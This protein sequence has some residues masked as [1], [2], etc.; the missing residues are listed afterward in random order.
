MSA[1]RV[2]SDIEMVKYNGITELTFGLPSM[3]LTIE[4][5]NSASLG[6]M[7]PLVGVA[8]GVILKFEL[9]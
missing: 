8:C 4:Y 1:R 2:L 5:I 7:E 6:W 9:A 3:F